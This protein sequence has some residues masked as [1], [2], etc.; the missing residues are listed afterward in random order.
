MYVVLTVD[1]DLMVE[2][3]G[4]KHETPLIY[5]DGMVGVLPVF[6]TKEQAEAYAGGQ[7]AVA[8]IIIVEGDD[9]RR[10]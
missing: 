7:Y 10:H 3:L 4:T 8:G 6:E 5:A 9:V 1:T 2:V